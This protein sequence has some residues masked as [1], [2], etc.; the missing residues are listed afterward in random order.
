MIINCPHCGKRSAAE[1]SYEGDATLK[2]PKGEQANNESAWYDYV[3]ARKNSVE[4]HY[5]LWHHLAGCRQYVVVTRN[6]RTH[7]I[8]ACQTVD[9]FR[10]QHAIPQG[11]DNDEGVMP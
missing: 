7:E 11:T 1:F 9:K 3:Y 10:Q 4:N 6:L 2:R 5:E 8:S